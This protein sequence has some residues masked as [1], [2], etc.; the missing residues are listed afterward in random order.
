MFRHINN[1]G[2]CY[3]YET[4]CGKSSHCIRRRRLSKF[5]YGIRLLS[6]EGRS[7]RPSLVAYTL[8]GSRVVSVGRNSYRRTHPE[9]SR[10]AT[11]TGN[12]HKQYLHAEI[13]ALVKSPKDAD[14]IVIVR[15]DKQGHP[16]CAKPCPVCQMAIRQFNPRMKVFH[17]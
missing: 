15:L 2:Y 14:T 17:T 8:K 7:S 11:L 1:G 13:S 12:P 16:A 4:R 10:F 9:Q 6:R 3:G 5:A